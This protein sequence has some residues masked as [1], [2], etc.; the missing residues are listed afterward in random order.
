M[1][2]FQCSFQQLV[3]KHPKRWLIISSL[4]MTATLITDVFIYSSWL[5]GFLFGF[6]ATTMFMALSKILKGNLAGYSFKKVD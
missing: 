5:T 1:N 3:D 6:N 2:F 4:I